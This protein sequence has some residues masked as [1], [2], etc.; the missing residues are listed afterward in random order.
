MRL[1]ELRLALLWLNATSYIP[2]SLTTICRYEAKTAEIT[3]G[4]HFANGKPASKH[5]Q[6]LLKQ[7]IH[8]ETVEKTRAIAF[9]HDGTDIPAKH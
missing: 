4:K 3:N 9:K 8:D 7:A 5:V 2:I 6:D 1:F